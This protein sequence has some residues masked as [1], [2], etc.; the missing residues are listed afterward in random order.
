MPTET[1]RG[2]VGRVRGTLARTTDIPLSDGQLLTRFAADRDEDAFAALVRRLGPM[3]LRVCRR[4]TGHCHSAEDAFQAVFLVLARRAAE[5]SPPERVGPWL[6]GVACRTAKAAR[7]ADRR[8]ARR[9]QPMGSLPDRPGPLPADPSDV[10]P[11]LDE[12]IRRLPPKYRD[13]LIACELQGRQRRELA[14]S[15]GIPEGTVASRLSTARRMLGER[16]ARRGVM[17]S[18]PALLGASRAA[19]SVVPPRLLAFAARFGR[20]TPGEVPGVVS[21]LV[22]Q[23]TRIMGVNQLR[24]GLACLVAVV[25]V[26]LGVASVDGQNRDGD[27]PVPAIPAPG[28]K[29][30]AARP[31]PKPAPKPAGPGKLLLWRKGHLTALA[32]DGTGETRVSEDRKGHMPNSTGAKWSPDG[33]RFAF[34]VRPLTPEDQPPGQDAPPGRVYVRGIEENEPGTDLGVDGEWVV[35]SPDGSSLVVVGFEPGAE[36]RP[37][38]IT[39]RLVDL[40]T[41]ETTALKL[42]DGLEFAVCDW[43]RD[44]KHFLAVG[45][46]TGE[47]DGVGRLYLVP[48]A[49]GAPTPLTPAGQAVYEGAV[50]SP[51]GRRVLYTADDP[52]RK[53]VEDRNRKEAHGLFVLDVRDKKPVRVAGQPI[54]A[55][56]DG[57]CWS[58]DGKR[59]AYLW[60]KETAVPNDPQKGKTTECNL[61]V[62]DADGGN[63]KAVVTETADGYGLILLGGVDWR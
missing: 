50:L 44:G 41:K 4:V 31:A 33:K 7:A 10:G 15:L 46:K 57:Y 43:S 14:R 22:R 23:G 39:N 24:A 30:P 9:E 55:W 53:G 18:V 54:D 5:V 1:L 40:K 56:I 36:G 26:A 6:Y 3:V 42:P 58:P 13:L 21:A 49:G 28:A 60:Q 11:V 25:A 34:M 63:A 20:A 51:D 35:W 19:G 61:V 8:R 27:P 48:R 38:S 59:M 16:L 29:T 12:E 17:L 62:A 47:K 37:G 2:V 32:P 45:A 52:E